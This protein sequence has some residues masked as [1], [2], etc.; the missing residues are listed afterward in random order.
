[1]YGGFTVAKPS[2]EQ[3]LEDNLKKAYNLWDDH[4]PNH[5]LFPASIR[6]HAGPILPDLPPTNLDPRLW[7]ILGTNVPS[8]F[9]R[10]MR[11][12]LRTVAE[13]TMNGAFFGDFMQLQALFISERSLKINHPLENIHAIGI[14]VT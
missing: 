14:G 2:G 10:Q 8:G 7:W 1:M 5:V 13:R 9:L 3:T 6:F 4:K 12:N 11:D